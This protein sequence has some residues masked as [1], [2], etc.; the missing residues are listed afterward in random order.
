MKK[1]KLHFVSQLPSHRQFGDET[2]LIYDQVLEK[3]SPAL[4]KWIHEFDSRYAVKS[5]EALKSVDAFPKHIKK[6]MKV[7]E[8]FSVR[9]MT[10]V[11]LGGG[12]VGDFGGFVASIFKRGVRLVHIPS[13]WLAAIDSS[14]GGKTALNIGG[15]KNQIGT[16]YPA[17]DIYLV[18]SVLLAQPSIRAEE[19][20]AEIYKVALL[21]GGSFWNAF[22]K[23]GQ[24]TS[25]SLWKFLKPAIA[26]K[27]AVVAKDPLETSGHRHFLNFGHSLG[28]ALESYYFLAHGIAVNYGMEFALRWSE[29]EGSMK[30]DVA[31]KLWGAPASRYLRSAAHDKLLEPKAARGMKQLL[32]ADKKKTGSQKLRFIFTQGPGRCFI[33]EVTFDEIMREISRQAVEARG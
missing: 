14:H 30:P 32:A 33:R 15:V 29:A 16:F 24:P 8:D 22:A 20:F 19:A 26:A 23:K 27:Y 18:K 25:E 3:I 2:V 4:R 11:V 21:Q 5:G 17:S 9:K 12:S 7:S 28:H 13:T 10:I 6:I 31:R 1:A